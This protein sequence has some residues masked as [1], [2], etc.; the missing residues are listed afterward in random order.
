M[1][2]SDE[3]IA[4]IEGEIVPASEARV[5]V[6]DH[7]FLF[8]DGVFEGIRLTAAGIFRFDD[9]MRRL[10]T[11]ASA[12]GIVVPGGFERVR[13][14]A[15]QT[16]RAWGAREGY[17]RLIVSRGVGALGIDSTTC[18][19]PAIVCIAAA[20]APPPSG[21]EGD[22]LALVTSSLRRPAADVL[23]PRVKSLNYLNNVLAKREAGLRGGDDAL[24]LNA[25][26]LVAEASAT[27]V[28]AIAGDRLDTPPPTDG[29]LEGL[30]RRTVLEIGP[31][32][33]FEPRERSLGRFDLFAADAV[34]LTGSRAGV[35]PV[36]SLD[37][38]PIAQRARPRLQQIQARFEECA[39][40]LSVPV[41]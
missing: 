9:H 20:P 33:G 37:G 12:V 36:A 3:S 41:Q 30:T 32:L 40:E 19:E 31:E 7:G 16:V 25:Q 1:K 15:R 39:I 38:S 8:G 18:P 5:P 34:F 24:V 26:G 27:N 17:L 4:W 11:A 13:E 6:L 21:Q 2:Q 35:V 14:V 10:E 29:A 28:F 23:D 22:G